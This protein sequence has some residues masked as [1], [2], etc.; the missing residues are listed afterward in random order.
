M[1]NRLSWRVPSLL[2]VNSLL[3]FS[4]SAGADVHQFDRNDVDDQVDGD[5][6]GGGRELGGG[7]G[8]GRR[9]PGAGG[10]NGAG[11]GGNNGGGRGGNN[12]G[13]P[14]HDGGW[15]NGDGRGPDGRIDR[16]REGRGGNR[17]DRGRVGRGR[18]P[19]P[20]PYDPNPRY[21]E[22]PCERDPRNCGNGGRGDHDGGWGNDGDW[23]DDGG[24]GNEQTQRAVY[25]NQVFNHQYIDLAQLAGGVIGNM[26]GYALTGVDVE[27][28]N[29]WGP[30]T[31]RLIVNNQQVDVQ[32]VWQ[33]YVQLNAYQPADILFRDRV[34][35]GVQGRVH[36]G[37]VVMHFQYLGRR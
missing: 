32:N 37:Q 11:R 14:D 25:L 18:R 28:L 33:R 19:D 7:R 9:Q 15:G 20:N 5:L 3:V 10:D 35:L 23:G 2:L 1:G 24:F 29:N 26:R 21:P 16:D 12:G 8:G 27:I 13:G 34:S 31:I 30:A 36:I 22:S 4:M 6:G 17:G